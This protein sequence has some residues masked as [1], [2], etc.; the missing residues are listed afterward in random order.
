MNKTLEL[1]VEIVGRVIRSNVV[2]DGKTIFGSESTHGKAAL[3][4]ALVELLTI[5]NQSI[6]QQR[7]C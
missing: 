3:D 2:V 5:F 1:R 7:H 6:E 4:M